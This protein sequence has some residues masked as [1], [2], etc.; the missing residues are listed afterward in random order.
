MEQTYDA[1]MAGGR[2]DLE[3]LIGRA[4]L[5]K[6]FRDVLLKNPRAAAEYLGVS[7]SDDQVARLQNLDAA[8]VDEV[9]DAFQG[10]TGLGTIMSIRLW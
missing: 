4:M 3:R 2:D 10:V 8:R 1:S 6:E 7:I 5:D 9:A